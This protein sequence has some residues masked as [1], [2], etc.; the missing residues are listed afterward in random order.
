MLPLLLLPLDALLAELWVAAVVVV[1]L[2][3]GEEADVS[4]AA[5][6]VEAVAG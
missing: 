3:V 4:V 5:V 1:G 6:A 2:A